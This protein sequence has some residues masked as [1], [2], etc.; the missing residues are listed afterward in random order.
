[1]VTA[2]AKDTLYEVLRKLRDKNVS[3]II[4]ERKTL[5]RVGPQATWTETVE[6]VGIVFLSDLMFL[7]R[8]LNFINFRT[9]L[10][11]ISPT[12][13]FIVETWQG[14]KSNGAG[15]I[16]DLSYLSDLIGTEK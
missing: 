15:F 16:R 4:V 5:V 8:Q 11:K 14:H 1:M 3:M 12:Q 13:T 2:N 7:L 9:V 6:T 10:N